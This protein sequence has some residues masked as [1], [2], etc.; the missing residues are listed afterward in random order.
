[1]NKEKAQIVDLSPVRDAA[2]QEANRNFA[3]QQAKERKAAAR[4]A[5]VQ[6]QI[7]KMASVKIM[8]KD[9]ELIAGK[10]QGVRDYV[11]KNNGMRDASPAQMMEF[12]RLIGDAKMSA[13]QSQNFREAWEQ[14]GL[15]VMKNQ[16]K[17][18][19]ESIDQHWKMALPETA[20]QWNIDDSQYKQNFD[21][22]NHVTKDLVPLAKQRADATQTPYREIF[23]E[24]DAKKA[25]Y[26]D[27]YSDPVKLEQANY[28][29]NNAKDKMGATTPEE[30]YQNKYAKYLIQNQRKAGPQ[31]SGSGDSKKGK[32]LL[33]WTTKEDGSKYATISVGG[34][35]PVPVTV[36]DPKNPGYSVT[37]QP[38]EYI[39]RK[40]SDGRN[41]IVLKATN[42]K[43]NKIEFLDYNTAQNTLFHGYQIE[44]PVAMMDNPEGTG[45]K[46]KGY[47]LRD[48]NKK[49]NEVKRKTKDGKIA[50]FDA[51]TKE[52]IRFE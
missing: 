48:K 13:D 5:E 20:G 22:F 21:Y 2:A 17:Y 9:Q 33:D 27:L 52:F 10:L 8:P 46:T 12:Q 11:V 7:A 28:D 23:T 36:E 38:M 40:A 19:P 3:A 29:F 26:D 24:A 39:Q 6:D 18:R 51:D 42:T 32:V 16:D 30:F 49:V 15:E 4:E 47:D 43:T 35:K 45:A 1:M 14:R 34:R 50:I 37:Y 25:I 44:N 41:E 31:A